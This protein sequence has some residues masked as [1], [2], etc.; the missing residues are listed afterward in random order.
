MTPDLFFEIAGLVIGVRAPT[1]AREALLARWGAYQIGAVEPGLVLDCSMDGLGRRLPW[2]AGNG[3]SE[4]TCDG[5]TYRLLRR[6]LELEL[7][8]GRPHTAICHADDRD[9][10]LEGALRLCLS[11]V[12][13]SEGGILL[14]ASAL[15]WRGQ[16]YVFTG[17][18]GAGKSTIIK[19][20]RDQPDVRS[21]GDE[22][23]VLRPGASGVT[24]HSTP[25]NGELE[26]APPG[27][28]S[29]ARLFFLCTPPE[30]LGTV[31][32]RGATLLRNVASHARDPETVPRLLRAVETVVA[33]VP[34]ATLARPSRDELA[35]AL[36]A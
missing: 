9:V 25:L 8:L 13:P 14:H 30:R 32:H 36:T 33:T 22:L 10:V 1:R 15:A 11:V 21:L 4:A 31:A 2:E 12:I 28:S 20:L 34:W 24:V 23:V 7:G 16:G 19:L 5:Q 29:L 3:A 27:A 6:D 18:S 35:A 26:P 17:I